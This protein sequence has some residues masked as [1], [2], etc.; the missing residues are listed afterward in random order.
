MQNQVIRG[1]KVAMALTTSA[2]HATTE[3]QE[4][5]Q[6]NNNNN[7]CHMMNLA[8]FPYCAGEPQP[9]LNAVINH[10]VHTLNHFNSRNLGYPTNQNFNYDGLAPLLQFHLNNAGDPFLGCSFSLNST[11]FEVSVLDWFANLW[12]IQKN[13]YWGY[14]TTGGTEA[15][16]HAILVGREQFPDGILYTSEDSHYSIFKIARIN[17]MQCVKVATLV[18]GE[19]DCAH[20]KHSLL[21]HNDKPA[22]INLNIGTTM[23]GGIDDIDVVIKTL[24]E[25]GFSRDRFYIHC[26][27]ALFGIMLPFLKAAPKIISFKKSIGSVSVSGHKFLGCPIP[28]GV[29]ITRLEYMNASSRNNVVE[30]IGSRDATITGSR[31]GHAPIFLWYAIKKKGSI[32]L[33]NE[34]ENCIMNARYLHNRLCDAGFGA[35]LNEYSNIVVFERPLDDEFSRRWNLACQGN[36]AHVVVMQHVTIHMLDSFVAEFMM[37][38]KRSFSCFKDYGTFKPLCIADEV[39]APN[40]SCS[41]HNLLS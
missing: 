40:C 13:K 37:M 6:Q 21:A 4:E 5:Q 33:Q 17:R 38:K 12:D 32:G 2:C 36:I 31:S 41:M 22:I 1:K 29:V 24:E 11:S 28:C 30:I 23:K 27:A 9:N 8:I 3:T 25:S 18:N 19:I 14:V 26:D 20:L 10:Y 35:M 16:L 34:V 39:G 7:A 15:N